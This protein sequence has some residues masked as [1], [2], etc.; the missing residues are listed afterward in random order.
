MRLEVTPWRCVSIYHLFFWSRKEAPRD[1]VNLPHAVG[2]RSGVSMGAKNPGVH[3]WKQ[4]KTKSIWT[5]V[6]GPWT[7]DRL[8][9]YF[10]ERYL[11]P[12]YFQFSFQTFRLTLKKFFFSSLTTNAPKNLRGMALCRTQFGIPDI[13]SLSHTYML[14]SFWISGSGDTNCNIILDFCHSNFFLR[15][16]GGIVNQIHQYEVRNHWL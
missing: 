16:K 8:M 10:L 7:L 3:A 13:S 12:V 15:H 9:P 1:F 11:E 5:Q 6:V 4:S 2:P 14:A